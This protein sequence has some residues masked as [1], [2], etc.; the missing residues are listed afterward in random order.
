MKKI[1]IISVLF[2]AFAFMSC[3]SDDILNDV[4]VDDT[5]VEWGISIDLPDWTTATH[6]N[7]VEPNYDV[8]FNQN[9]VL[10]IDLVIGEDEWE[11]MQADL[12]ANLG[13]SAK[14]VQGGRPG[15]GGGGLTE[16]DPVWV[17]CSVFFEGKEWYKVGVRFKGNSSLNSTYSEG[18]SKLP[19]K[20]DF[21]QFESD[22]PAISNQRFY[23]FKQLSLKNNFDDASFIREKV[24]S[25]LFREFGLVSSH[26]AFCALY[27]DCGS[28]LKYFGLYTIV[29]E[30][31]DTVLDNQYADGNGN[32]YKPDGGA[33]SFA[34]GTYN[35][36]EM[37]KQ[38][39]ENLAD[40][41]DVY[42][43]YNAINSSTRTSD[44]EEWK[45]LLESKLDT[46]VFL[47]WL[48][49]NT[50]IQNWDT[51]G[52]MT[53]NYYLYNNPSSNLLEWIPWD[54]NEAFKEG[55]QG[56]SLSIEL[57]EV[58]NNW[59]LIS[60][61]IDVTEYKEKYQAYLQQFIDKVFVPSNMQKLYDS[62]YMLLKEFAYAEESGYTFLRT[63][64]DFD[65][66][67]ETLKNHV[68]KR[69]AA[70]LSYLE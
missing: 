57:S 30:V 26:T 1:N 35:E 51:Y 36:S 41:S 6:G 45:T 39:N 7:Q 64:T 11:T 53:H 24:A 29:E 68:L 62:Y 20:L 37:V 47:K 32:L 52:N 25:D 60:Y 70:V 50:T 15:M 66:A 58:G 12:R 59:P 42:D 54:A 21:D 8:V 48:A 65:S 4:E 2:L 19:F 23:G 40:Y 17:T 18:N 46:D 44:L 55:K 10:R 67:I 56:G 9:E 27:V 33:A 22:Y 31:D 16:F 13:S 63:G 34:M 28:G 14:G 3:R 38:N 61:L 49:A 43:L 5:T 69:N